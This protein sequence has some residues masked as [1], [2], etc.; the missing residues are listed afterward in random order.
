[1]L[2][3]R[4]IAPTLRACD[5]STKLTLANAQ[6]LRQALF[7][8]IGRYV[9]LRMSDAGNIDAGELEM[10]CSLGF[11]VWLYQRVRFPGWRPADHSGGSDGTSAA[12]QALAAGYPPGAHLFL[13]P[14]GI[15]GTREE[16]IRFAN[17]WATSVMQLHYRAGLYVGYQVPLSALDL[18]D[19]PGFN[20]YASDVGNRKVAVRE[21][22]MSQLAERTV[23]GVRIDPVIIRTDR[24]GDRPMVCFDDAY[25][26]A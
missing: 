8:A 13:D 14:E 3:A 11:D 4:V 6:A 12:Q 15:D 20:Q 2:N 19:L 24:M 1:M 25:Q 9:G 5:T 10:L 21:T 22:S 7:V 18:Y 17:D 26:A 16:T 23:A